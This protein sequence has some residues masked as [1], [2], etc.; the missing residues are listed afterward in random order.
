MNFPIPPYEVFRSQPAVLAWLNLLAQW[1]K[2]VEARL[3]ALEGP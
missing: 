3:A 2:D 1:A